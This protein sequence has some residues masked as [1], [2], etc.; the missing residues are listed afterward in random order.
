MTYGSNES[1]Y[2]PDEE[3]DLNLRTGTPLQKSF[4]KVDVYCVYVHIW[5]AIYL[6]PCP[7]IEPSTTLNVLHGFWNHDFDVCEIGLPCGVP[8]F[9]GTVL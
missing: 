6:C 7:E 3:L 1:L 2:Y 9:Q 5:C 8:G 4:E